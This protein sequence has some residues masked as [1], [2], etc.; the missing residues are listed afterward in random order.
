MYI[1]NKMSVLVGMPWLRQLRI[2]KSK[3][4]SECIIFLNKQVI[5]K[6]IST[7]TID[8]GDS[9]LVGKISLILNCKM[10]VEIGKCHS[11][12]FNSNNYKCM[13]S[14]LEIKRLVTYTLNY[15]TMLLQALENKA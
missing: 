8:N 3:L 10:L 12:L 1:G 13:S 11:D 15:T 5:T 14:D 7:V 2:K 9:K 6:T 4:R